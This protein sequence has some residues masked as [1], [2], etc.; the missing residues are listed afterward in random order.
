MSVD[1]KFYFLFSKI[2]KSSDIME[3]CLRVW[4]CYSTGK[5]AKQN[6]VIYKTLYIIY[7]VY[8]PSIS[9]TYYFKSQFIA[10]Y[11]LLRQSLTT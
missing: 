7:S 5:K 3:I 10:Y 9:N 2:T 1:Q 4:T 6:T 8:D 11:F